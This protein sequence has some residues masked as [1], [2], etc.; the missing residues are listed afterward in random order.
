MA[1]VASFYGTKG[2]ESELWEPSPHLGSVVRDLLFA[3]TQE[4]Q[5]LGLVNR[6]Y[7]LG[8]LEQ[9]SVP[10]LPDADQQTVEP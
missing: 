6:E 9:M 8:F 4:V 10:C 7:P 3:A 5:E 1:L 2:I